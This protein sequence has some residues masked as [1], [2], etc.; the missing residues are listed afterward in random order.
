MFMNVVAL[1]PGFGLLSAMDTLC[2]Q[3]HG[4]NQTAKMG[5]YAL[6]ALFILS[7]VFLLVS[8]VLWNAHRALLLLGQPPLV[9]EMAGT[10]SR[11]LLP[12]IPFCYVYEIIRKVSQSRNEAMPMLFSSVACNLVNAILGYYLVKY[13]EMGWIGAAVARSASNV[14]LVPGVIFGMVGGMGGGDK[15]MKETKRESGCGVGMVENAVKGDSRG[16]YQE[17]KEDAVWNDANGQVV[18]NGE[19]EMRDEDDKE[20]L[21]HLWTGFVASE[22][23]SL[24][25]V[26]GFLELGIPGAL[27]VM[28]E[29]WAFEALAL[30]CG[31]L[32]G[33]EAIIGIGANAIILNVSSTT[34]MVYMGMSVAGNVRLGNALGAGDAHRARVA[35]NLT[36]S[37]GAITALINIGFLLSTRTTLP[38]CFT[39]D[40]DIAK[41]AEHLFVIAACYQLPDAINGAVQGIFRGS[42]RQALA[43]QWNFV[44]YYCIGIPLA[45]VFG[46]AF[47]GGVEGLWWGITVGLSVIATG[48]TGIVL[49]SDWEAF[50]SE[51]KARMNG[52]EG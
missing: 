7:I 27:Q 12:G 30:L 28:F 15:R 36:L 50:S 47:G 35:S 44:A 51:A 26:V 40:V 34:Y 11:Y 52:G 19:I 17:I 48:C 22:A 16:L 5:T 2:S 42:G 23:L 38:W 21:H 41:E 10:F 25:S 32:P 39:T 24:K 8:T 29:W 46:I 18:G 4:A 49:R 45:Y 43:A 6:T 31:I 13:T 9:C 3:A 14:V 1:A 33:D 20:F 37:L